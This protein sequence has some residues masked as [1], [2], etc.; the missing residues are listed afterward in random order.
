V[1]DALDRFVD[2][3]CLVIGHEGAAQEDR[4]IFRV[5]AEPQACDQH[6]R[7]Q[8]GEDS[9]HLLRTVVGFVVARHRLG[10]R[11]RAAVPIRWHTF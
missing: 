10:K 1:S 6:Q 7:Q 4:H 2:H 3:A 11:S 9:I 5:S 8:P